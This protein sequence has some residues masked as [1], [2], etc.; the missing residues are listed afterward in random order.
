MS[1]VQEGMSDVIVPILFLSGDEGICKL[2]KEMVPEITTVSTK[3]YC[4]LKSLYILFDK[5]DGYNI[6]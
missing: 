4:I 5:R 1:K 6:F 2:A 3:F